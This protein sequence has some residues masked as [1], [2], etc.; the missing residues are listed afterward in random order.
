MSEEPIPEHDPFGH[1][2]LDH[3]NNWICLICKV[4]VKMIDGWRWRHV[5]AQGT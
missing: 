1:V 4:P 2:G 3:S 5:N